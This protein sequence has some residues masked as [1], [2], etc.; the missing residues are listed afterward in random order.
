MSCYWTFLKRIHSKRKGIHVDQTC[1]LAKNKPQNDIKEA[2]FTMQWNVIFS[3]T[4][5]S[6]LTETAR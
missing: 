2:L 3:V 5:N 1:S 4:L 6:F